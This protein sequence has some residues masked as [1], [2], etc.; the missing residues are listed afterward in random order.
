VEQTKSF[1]GNHNLAY[2]DYELFGLPESSRTVDTSAFEELFGKDESRLKDSPGPQHRAKTVA[3][4]TEKKP[5]KKNQPLFKVLSG[6]MTMSFI[7]LI[8]S[9][10]IS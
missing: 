6:L 7:L 10:I 1:G 4:K 8:F 2:D 9:I 3:K 5:V